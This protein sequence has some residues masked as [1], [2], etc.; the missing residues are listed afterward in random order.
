M[1]RDK[2]DGKE[3]SSER[4]WT[5]TPQLLR[6]AQSP[7]PEGLAIVGDLRS[8]VGGLLWKSYRSILLW[9]QTDPSERAGLFDAE[10]ASRRSG[11]IESVLERGHSELRDALEVT[12]AML[13]EPESLTPEVVARAARRIAAWAHSSSAS[14]TEFEFLRVAA[15][16]DPSN[17][18]LALLVARAALERMQQGMAEA[19][20]FR[21]IGLARHS[22]E[23]DPYVEAYLAHGEMMLERRALPS[24]RESFIKAFRRSSRQGKRDMKAKALTSLFA[25]EE[26]AGNPAEAADYADQ[27]LDL[28]SA[29]DPDLRALARDLAFFWLRERHFAL[30]LR[31]FRLIVDDTPRADLPAVLGGMARAGGGASD[32]EAFEDARARLEKLGGGPGVAEAWLDVARAALHLDRSEDAEAAAEHARTFGRQVP[33]SQIDFLARVLLDKSDRDRHTRPGTADDPDGRQTALADRLE[34]LLRKAK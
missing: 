31:T 2:A 25:L 14:D 18:R 12:V 27:A 29:P 23:W 5:P 17:P 16:A 20:L 6:D 15:A 9:S 33:G 8:P 28:Y 13:R 21:T 30:G 1:D 24:A 26:V 19:W 7:G 10:A 4:R 34:S 3:K 22:R 32:S 11:E